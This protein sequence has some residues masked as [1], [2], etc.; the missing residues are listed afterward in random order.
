ML[1]RWWY[2]KIND[3]EAGSEQIGNLNTYLLAL[4]YNW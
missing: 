1:T 4:L 3:L 2:E